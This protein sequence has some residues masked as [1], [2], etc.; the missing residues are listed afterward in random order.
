MP[1]LIH[2]YG[3]DGKGKTSAALGLA[4]RAVGA[5]RRVLFVQFLKNGTSSEM[6]LLTKLPQIETA[7]CPT[8]HGFYK[9][10]DEAERAAARED[11]EA[12]LQAALA[13]AAELDLLILDEAVSACNHQLIAEEELL[14]FLRHKPAEL[15]LVLTGRKPSAA[16]LE[17]A[18]YVTEMRKIKHP[19]DRGVKARK[20]I[21]F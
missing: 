13:R 2:I 9:N 17:L 10:M 12:L 6:K 18:D 5:G 16:L 14:G 11:Y 7:F 20:G 15:E 4:L 8:Q 1:G 19:F 3:G 21:E